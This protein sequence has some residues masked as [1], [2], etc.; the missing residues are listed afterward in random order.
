MFYR[1]KSKDI[2]FK[3]WW[4]YLFYDEINH[5]FFLNLRCMRIQKCIIAVVMWCCGI[6]FA[7]AQVTVRVDSVV[8][9][10]DTIPHI[11][12]P[13]LHKYPPRQF[14]NKKAKQQHNRLVR[15][16]KRVYPLARL[17]RQT[18]IETYEVMQLL[19]ESEHKAH[20]KRVEKGLLEQYGKQFRK[21]SR[22]QGRLLVK[23]VDRE[24]NNTGYEITK[25]FLGYTR[26]NI[27]Q[28]IALLFG[29]SLNKH[30]DPEGEDKEIE[31][32]VLLIESGQL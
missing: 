24:C 11:T 30:Y 9:N 8:Y 12:L 7:A 16:V 31:R 20:L 18:I 27:Y 5:I 25:A 4:V 28:G 14:K 6:I 32:I 26:A 19:P 10:G 13:T 29:N 1:S 21:L 2:F 17:V 3:S 22:T 23:L 15:N